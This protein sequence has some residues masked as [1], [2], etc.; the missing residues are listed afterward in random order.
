MTSNRLII[1]KDNPATRCDIC[2]LTDCFDVETQQCHRCVGIALPAL[3]TPATIPGTTTLQ[4][5]NPT[6]STRLL[7]WISHVG[8]TFLISMGAT[9]L[10]AIVEAF[11]LVVLSGLI[12]LG[13]I[14]VF[15]LLILLLCVHFVTNIVTKTVVSITQTIYDNGRATSKTD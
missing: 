3:V 15:L 1:R 2:H 8:L 11:P 4:E 14:I 6:F 9:V 7:K 12:S 13:S 10:L 5:L